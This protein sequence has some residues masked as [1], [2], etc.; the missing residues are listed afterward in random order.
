[1]TTLTDA[2][3][4][5]LCHDPVTIILSAPE[6]SNKVVRITNS[7]AVKFGQ[8]VTAQEFTNQQIAQRRLDANIVN[9]PKVH[10]FIQ[11]DDIG[12]I[13]MDYID[14]E[15]LNLQRAKAMAEKLG[16]VLNQSINRRRRLQ[17]HLEVDQS[18][19]RYGLSMKR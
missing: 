5:S 9:V 8:Y 3:I 16:K 18:L 15:T 12:Y 2:E 19:V 4:T 17:D 13:V 10:R 11:E 1:M 14:G 7:L 6:C